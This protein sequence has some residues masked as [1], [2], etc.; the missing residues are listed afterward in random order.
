MLRPFRFSEGGAKERSDFRGGCNVRRTVIGDTCP[1]RPPRHTP[2]AALAP[3]S[4]H[5]RGMTPCARFAC[6]SPFA[7]QKGEGTR[8]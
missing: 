6:A 7:S 5:E 8:R 1:A 3:L 4:S 2:L